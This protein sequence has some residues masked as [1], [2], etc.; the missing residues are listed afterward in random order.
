MRSIQVHLGMNTSQT[1]HVN[2]LIVT[3]DFCYL[4]EVLYDSDS[5]LTVA[6]PS[7]QDVHVCDYSILLTW[8]DSSYLISMSKVRLCPHTA[9]NNSCAYQCTWF[10]SIYG[11]IIDDDSRTT[12]AYVFHLASCFNV[13]EAPRFRTAHTLLLIYS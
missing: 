4:K 7:A 10:I 13:D 6:C 1:I 2:K 5:S 9:H 3:I 11:P 8:I 12:C